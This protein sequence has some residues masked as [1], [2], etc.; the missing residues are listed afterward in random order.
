MAKRWRLEVSSID[1]GGPR[2]T[3]DVVAPNWMAAIKE[4][5]AALGEVAEIPKGASCQVAPGGRVSV[6]AP[7][8]RRS[9]Q[10]VPL[11]GDAA[12]APPSASAHAARVSSSKPP[13]SHELIPLRARDTEPT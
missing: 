10:L 11:V 9:Y 7:A 4:G 12:N 2:R 1:P 5:R 3:V 13:S 6:L 8:E